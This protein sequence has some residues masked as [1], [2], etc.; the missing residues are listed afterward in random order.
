MLIDA[1]CEYAHY[2]SD[3]TRTFPVLGR[4]SEPQKDLYQ[5]VLNVQKECVAKC[6]V[7][8]ATSMAELHRLSKRKICRHQVEKLTMATGCTLMAQELRQIGFK[9]TSGEVERKLV[10]QVDSQF[11]VC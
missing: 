10:S 7:K 4:F 9:L 2:T 11:G 1:G 8:E 3:I 6:T 5:A